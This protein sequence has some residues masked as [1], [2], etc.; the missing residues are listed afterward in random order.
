M[1]SEEGRLCS[2]PFV[3]EDNHVVG[4]S[5]VFYYDNSVLFDHYQLVSQSVDEVPSR[6]SSLVSAIHIVVYIA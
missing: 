5:E 4:H 3:E 6:N 2:L 1:M